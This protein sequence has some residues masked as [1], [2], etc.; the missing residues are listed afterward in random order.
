MFEFLFWIYCHVVVGA[1]R[2]GGTR[3]DKRSFRSNHGDAQVVL[4]GP[5][6]SGKT[7]T[8]LRLRNALHVPT[9]PSMEVRS[10]TVLQI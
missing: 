9:V 5:S 1:L 3:G 10:H 6:G 4:L 8:M 2:P 7:A